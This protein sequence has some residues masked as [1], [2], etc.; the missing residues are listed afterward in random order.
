M[1]TKRKKDVILELVIIAQF[2]TNTLKKLILYLF[3][4]QINDSLKK[5]T[6]RKKPEIAVTISLNCVYTYLIVIFFCRFQSNNHL[7][8]QL[9][10]L[11]LHPHRDL[12]KVQSNLYKSLQVNYQICPI[13][14][15][16]EYPYSTN[17]VCYF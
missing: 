5:K 11:N 17:L 1:F 9:L 12:V 13:S 3:N 6:T 10:L 16:S 4:V 2:S 8:D 14:L 7:K 15:I